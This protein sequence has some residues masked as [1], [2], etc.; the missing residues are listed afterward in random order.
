MIDHACAGITDPAEVFA[1]SFRIS[2]RLSWTHPDVASF[3]TGR[4][5]DLLDE[6]YGLAPR[7]LRDVK[8]GQAAGCF[9][10]PDAEV[11]IS[12]V[13][14][15]LLGLLRQHQQ[16]PERLDEGAV[17][18]FAEAS[19]AC[20]AFPHRKPRGSP[21]CR[22][23]RSALGRRPAAPASFRSAPGLEDR[24]GDDQHVRPVPPVDTALP[25]H[26]MSQPRQP[27]SRGDWRPA[28][29]VRSPVLFVNLRS[30]GGAAARAGVAERARELGV[31]VII[32]DP[33]QS[34]TSLA[35]AA[36][37]SGAGALGMAG[38][39]GSLAEVAAVAAAN[40]LPFVCVPAGT[41]N[42]FALDLGVD[43]RDLTGA[44]EAF[45]DGFE[46]LID[47]GDV[48]G[49]VFLN[50]VSLGVYG[51]AVRRPEYRDAKVRT[52]L[53]TAQ[54]VA[55]PSGQAPGL[56]LTDDAGLEHRGVDV[57]LVSN[58]PYALERPLPRGTRPA[59]DSG[60]LGI[61]IIDPP[62]SGP[63]PPGRCWHAPRLEVSAR[64]PVHAGVDG[65]PADLVPPLRFTIR[66]AALRVRISRRHPGSSPATRVPAFIP[67]G[68]R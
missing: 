41:R 13:A 43:R 67:P 37:A 14:G 32:L 50:N 39:D 10:I 30:G 24:H 58:N 12:A 31:E 56:C 51:E 17:D 59:L 61:V 64:E 60:Q 7:A 22:A 47:V 6:P 38:G 15:A 54:Q 8:A 2:G 33:G 3:L 40:E 62:G 36:A 18:H 53:Q 35:S 16:H 55:G 46:R 4:G 9:T 65:E 21:P 48:N 11:G 42:H 57:V 49:R 29:P 68:R 52:L 28:G 45:T 34:L 27:L 1:V 63:P 66:P 19:C 5:L 26:A 23:R 25:E 20:S 44:L